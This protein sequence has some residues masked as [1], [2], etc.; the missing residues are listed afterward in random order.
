M[1]KTRCSR[2]CNCC[3]DTKRRLCPSARPCTFSNAAFFLG[4][5]R[6]ERVLHRQK[7]VV[8]T[9]ARCCAYMVATNAATRDDL[10]QKQEKQQRENRVSDFRRNRTFP[11]STAHFDGRFGNFGIFYP[12]GIFLGLFWPSM[13]AVTHR[14]PTVFKNLNKHAGSPVIP[15]VFKR[16]RIGLFQGRLAGKCPLFLDICEK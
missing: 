11:R 6:W 7:C 13:W 8:G 14:D 1:Q 16:G 2:Q 10:R 5:A 9:P 3:I 15:K 12:P 4:T